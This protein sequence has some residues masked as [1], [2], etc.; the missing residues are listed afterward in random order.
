MIYGWSF[1][2][3]PGE[4]AR[5]LS[6]HIT[7]VPQGTVDTR[8]HALKTD[9]VQKTD[10]RITV[11]T[12][13]HLSELQNRRSQSWKAAGSIETQA[14]G[15]GALDLS[16]I[17]AKDIMTRDGALEDAARRAIRA[18]LRALERNRPRR[19]RG[20]LALAAFPQ[21]SIHDGALTVQARFRLKI[22]EIEPYAVY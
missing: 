22:T 10:T 4:K 2:Y 13:Y 20:T 16:P 17:A 6:E 14:S 5:R 11:W 7:L 21:Y 9:L 8:E 19:A 1:E 12:D 15:T 3:E 18:R